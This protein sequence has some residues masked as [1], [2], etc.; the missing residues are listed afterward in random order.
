ME[1]QY[2]EQQ[3]V[4]AQELSW[5]CTTQHSDQ[6]PRLISGVRAQPCEVVEGFVEAFEDVRSLRR[7]CSKMLRDS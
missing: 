3:Q 5:L 6:D 7:A 1:A 2:E 4:N